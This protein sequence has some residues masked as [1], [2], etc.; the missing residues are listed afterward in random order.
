M[1]LHV[2]T[3]GC[4]FPNCDES[5]GTLKDWKRHENS[6]H[7][8]Q[9]TWRCELCCKLSND[10]NIFTNHLVS[11]HDLPRDSAEMNEACERMHL[12][13]EGHGH[14]W[15]GFC[16]KLIK[17][18]AG[19]QQASWKMRLKHISEHFDYTNCKIGDWVDIE[20][21]KKKSE[22]TDDNRL[23]G[24]Q[25][26]IE[27]DKLRTF[28]SPLP[29]LNETLPAPLFPLLDGTLNG[30]NA[31][32]GVDRHGSK[33]DLEEGITNPS[34]SAPRRNRRVEF[35]RLVI[36]IILLFGGLRAIYVNMF[37]IPL[38]QYSARE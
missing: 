28:P 23:K 5:F 26:F 34:Y 19:I 8:L 10:V 37:V 14:F 15:C 17:Q 6:Q 31:P 1:K 36:S 18:T 27:S 4:T 16:I 11:E 7:F 29:L 32:L 2:R 20:Q 3:Y 21:Q 12:G 9:E 30:A 35:V 38:E 25:I 13:R 22:I 24:T 33:K